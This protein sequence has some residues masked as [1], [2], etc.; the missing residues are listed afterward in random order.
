[1]TTKTATRAKRLGPGRL[2]AEATAGLP[3][4]LLDAAMI[5]VSERG[6]SDT[7]MDQIAKAAGASTKTIYARYSNKMEIL[8]AVIRRLVDRTVEAHRRTAPLGVDRVSPRDYLIGLG[9]DICLR[10]ST[11][12]AALNR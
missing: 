12:A 6:F 11:D 2:S 10:I 5:L 4:R 8:Q 3:N 1:M 9:T 7:T